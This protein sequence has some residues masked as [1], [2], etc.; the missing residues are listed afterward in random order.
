MKIDEV[1]HVTDK[2]ELQEIFVKLF[3][4]HPVMLKSQGINIKADCIKIEDDRIYIKPP[5]PDSKMQVSAIFIRHGE[6]IFFTHVIPQGNVGEML[7]FAPEGIQVFKATRKEARKN[8]DETPAKKALITNIISSPV[9][10]ESFRHNRSR[11]EWIRS[12]ITGKFEGRFQY[13]RVFFAGDRKPD[14]RMK[15]VAQERRPVF[16]PAIRTRQEGTDSGDYSRYMNEIY[17]SDP[18]LKDGHFNSEIIVPLLY[19]GMM[20]FGY[21][22]I[23][24]FDTLHE[25]ALTYSKR[26]GLA[27]SE[28]VS[29][30][31]LL[32]RPS[33]DSM[34]ITDLSTSGIG[35]LFRER[36][37]IKHFREDECL[38]FTVY[39]PEKKQATMMSRVININQM[40][41]YYR[42][43]CTI[44]NIDPI[45]DVNYQQFL[46]TL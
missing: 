35:I 27:F 44:S 14:I 42:V 40:N 11:S 5:D 20:P 21:I 43:G 1:R 36:A 45:G 10:E 23:N 2:K 6:E 13:T 41:N 37:L 9:V 39:M 28:S 8:T 26:M 46:G 29:K 31:M 30:D 4:G 34:M 24:H 22:Q 33:E 18:L 12:E 16:I 19:R 3:A 15:W 25:D 7:I 17:Y 32:F 38:V